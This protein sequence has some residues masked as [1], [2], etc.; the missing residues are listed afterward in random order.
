M[1]S[2]YDGNDPKQR[3]ND[4]AEG[5]SLIRTF[6]DGISRDEFLTDKMRQYAVV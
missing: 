3:L 5:V 2:D 6:I 4:I 1:S